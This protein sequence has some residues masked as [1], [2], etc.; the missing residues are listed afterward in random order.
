[1]SSDLK[2]DFFGDTSYLTH[3]LHIYPAKFP[4]QLPRNILKEF[5]K[6]GDIVLD[7]FVGS[8]TTLV[9]AVLVNV[10]SIGVDTN[11]LA[12]LISKVKTTPIDPKQLYLVDDLCGRVSASFFELQMGEK[13]E[14]VIP[15]IPNI[16]HWF[17]KNVVQELSLINKSILSVQ[18]KDIIDLALVA[19]S[20]IIV[21]VS[22]QESDTRFAAINKNIKDGDTIR[23]FLEKLS[24][25]K[26]IMKIFWEKL[27]EKKVKAKILNIDVRNL[28]RYLKHPVDIVI[29]SP[30]YA[31]TYDYYLYHK[32][33]M[34]WLN[35]DVA[36]A[37]Q[38]EIGSRREYSSL[39]KGKGKWKQ[40]L[41]ES[42]QEILNVLKS[43]KL[44][45]VVIGD[46][47][48]QK[49][50]VKADIIITEIATSL[51][52]KVIDIISSDLSNHSKVFNPAFTQKGKKEHLIMLRKQ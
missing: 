42:F 32:F 7:P 47:V 40:D 12:C 28:S 39:K 15:N 48:I 24:E 3:G 20:S 31:N 6:P 52:C 8:G 2:F 33:R 11:P 51:N 43:E 49:E 45:F 38:T 27:P 46:S 10:N 26:K 5:A 44:A 14:D 16:I 17:Q 25:Y 18:K 1:M 50:L 23:F 22:N 19:L 21:R 30:P 4:P 9:E 13:R 37:Q 35:M 36:S 29:T 34:Y 41:T